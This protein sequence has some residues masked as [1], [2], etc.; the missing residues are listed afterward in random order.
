MAKISYEEILSIQRK[1]NIVDIVRD[2]VPLSQKGKNFFGVC[3][4][5]DDHNP[6][7]SVSSEK[8]MYKCFVCGASGNVFNF[9]MEY[10]KVSYYE[11]VKIVADKVGINIDI[12]INKEKY[13]PKS[14]LY[15]IYDISYKIY[16]NNLNT[17]YGKDAREY[18]KRRKIDNAIIKEF[19]IGLS[20]TNTEISTALNKKGFSEMDIIKS[21]LCLKSNNHIYDIYKNRIM[22]PLTDLNGNVVAFSGRVYDG[23]KENKYVNTMETEIFKKGDLLYNYHIAKDEARKEKQIIVVEGFMDVIRLSTIGIKNVVALMGTALTKMQANLIRKLSSNII[24]MFDGDKAGDKATLSFLNFF[25]GSDANIKVVRLE[26]DLDPDEYILKNGKDKLI[27]HLQHPT[28]S[29]SYKIDNLK[30]DI[31][32]RDSKDVSK[33]VNL[34]I[35]ELE[36]ID[37][38]IVRDIEAK[39]ISDISGISLET[40]NSNI[41]V[42]K[43]S[44]I[45]IDKIKKDKVKMDKY[46]KASKYIIYNMIKNNNMILYYYNNLSYLPFAL[47][48]KLASEIVLFYKKYN[49]FNINDFITYLKDKKEL[50]D[51]VIKIDDMDI[52]LINDISDMDSYFKTIKEYINK[53]KITS[54]TNELKVETSDSKR[55]EIAQKIV[56]IKMKESI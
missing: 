50:I 49:S 43:K 8:Q 7:M 2:Y 22:F 45:V 29:I 18:L 25:K 38:D 37:D 54:L 1:V 24:L 56:E 27:Y 46:D 28:N 30:K 52:D 48:R 21:G 14:P 9:I 31:D 55:R 6:S 47:D 26:D 13:I 36:N 10:E 39:K 4:F 35:K 44:D 34:A 42:N 11:A 3:P 12:E 41:N 16:Q 53:E 17:A 51:L 32:F 23:T 20:T 33:Y 15:D 19:K 40:I 5:H